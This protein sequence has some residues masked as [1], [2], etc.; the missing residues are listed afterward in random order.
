M[1]L[2]PIYRSLSDLYKQYKELCIE[3][4]E[5]V[6]SR[7]TF[8]KLFHEKNLSL[9]TLKK[10]KCD[11][12]C[13]HAVGNISTSD[14]EQHIRRKNRARQGKETDKMKATSGEFILLSMDL[15]SVKICPY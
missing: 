3:N 6:L 13:G 10:D 15:E 12:C 7:F 1:Y 14:Y 5:L 9:Y 4:E 11:T 2:E 8:E